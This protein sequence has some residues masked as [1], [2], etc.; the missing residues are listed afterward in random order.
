MG[1]HRGRVATYES[2]SSVIL[3]LTDEDFNFKEIEIEGGSK[4]EFLAYIETLPSS[5]AA[6]CGKKAQRYGTSKYK[7]V[8]LNKYTGAWRVRISLEFKIY[9]VGSFENEKEAALAYD[10]A[11][12]IAFGEYARTNQMMFPEDFK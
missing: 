10:K 8:S 12:V 1:L 5:H 6:T 11:A 3:N 2:T 4:K 9:S 7:G